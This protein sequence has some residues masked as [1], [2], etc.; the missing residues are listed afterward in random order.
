M[1]E[2]EACK[3]IMGNEKKQISWVGLIVCKG[4]NEIVR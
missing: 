2:D 1:R 3:Y 4:E